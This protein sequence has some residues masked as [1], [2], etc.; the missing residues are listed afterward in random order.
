MRQRPFHILSLATLALGLASCSRGSDRSE[1]QD[2][3]PVVDDGDGTPGGANGDNAPVVDDGNGPATG[4]DGDNAPVSFRTPVPPPGSAFVHLFE[5]KWTDIAKE[6]EA[7]LGPAGFEAVQVSPPSEHAVLAGANYPWWQRYQTVSYSLENSRSGTLDEFED[8]VTRCARV[9]VGIY[10]DAVINHMTGQQGGTG[11]NGTV[12]TKYDYPGTYTEADFHTP[13]CGIADTDYASNPTGVQECELLS[14][15]DLNTGDDS[16]QTKIAAYLAGLVGL[17]VRGFRIDAAKHIAAA[18]IE[19]IV[20]KV[21]AGVGDEKAPYYFLEVFSLGVEAITPETYLPIGATIGDERAHV[22][23][24]RYSLLGNPFLGRGGASLSDLAQFGG[25]TSG[26]VP[27][28]RAVVFVNNHDTQRQAGL[29]YQD[30]AAF[31]LATIFMLAHP[32]GYPSLMS[33]YA[34]VRPSGRDV[35]PPSDTMGNTQSLYVEGAATPACS[36]EIIPPPGSWVC[37]HRRGYVPGML[38]FRK[39]TVAATEVTNFWNNGS[40]QI[41]FGRGALGF[42]A[43]NGE[44]EPLT[45]SFETGLP[46]GVYCDVVVGSPSQEQCAGRSI[47]V[48]AGGTAEIT[49]EPSSAAALHVEARL[50]E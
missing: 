32:Y 16:V 42:V 13:P 14:L 47:E 46:E 29:F 34:F 23:E 41:A 21:R 25:P 28:E 10:V 12:F 50:T 1:V 31:D 20:Q 45:R 44:P 2:V 22:I 18:D 17:G 3:D 43:I 37:E 36:E 6:C 35:G 7:F 5:W 27:S 4:D 19:T 15:S 30:G 48:L 38:A 24:F 40:N 33:S 49:L 8:M 39:A 9:G 26:F 11:S